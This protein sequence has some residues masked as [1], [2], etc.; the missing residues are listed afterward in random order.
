MELDQPTAVIPDIFFIHQRFAEVDNIRLIIIQGGQDGFRGIKKRYQAASGRCRM[1]P[2]DSVFYCGDFP[3]RL[4]NNDTTDTIDAD[5]NKRFGLKGI[6]YLIDLNY[7][8]YWSAG[9]L[10]CWS[11]G[12][13]C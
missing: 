9:V 10:E 6:L 4:G 8:K 2:P 11:F 3:V 12:L 13:K 1:D 7:H 5:F